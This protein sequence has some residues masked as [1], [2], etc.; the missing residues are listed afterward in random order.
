MSE[1][2]SLITENSVDW[3]DGPIVTVGSDNVPWPYNHDLEQKAFVD[4]QSVV[5]AFEK[6]YGV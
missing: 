4:V 5:T 3:L 2:A 6:G 1:V